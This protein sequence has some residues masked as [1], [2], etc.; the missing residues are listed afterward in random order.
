MSPSVGS[1][2]APGRLGDPTL[3]IATDPRADPRMV[4]MFTALGIEGHADGA[5]R[6]A[7]GV[8]RRR[9]G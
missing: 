7:R 9:H 4:A 8:A 5:P 1:A 6:G 3:T 2:T